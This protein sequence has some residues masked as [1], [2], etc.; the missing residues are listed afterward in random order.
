[1]IIF[2]SLLLD[3]FSNRFMDRLYVR[4]TPIVSIKR[5]NQRLFSVWGLFRCVTPTDSFF[6]QLIRV[7]RTLS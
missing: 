4:T 1:M 2:T 6:S 7:L 5:W 3:D